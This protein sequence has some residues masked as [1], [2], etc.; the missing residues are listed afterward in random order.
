M[1]EPFKKLI[2]FSPAQVLAIEAYAIDND[3]VHGGNPHFS[4]AVRQL[5]NIG[6]QVELGLHALKLGRPVEPDE[7]IQSEL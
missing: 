5:I 2:K 7:P 4:A 1:D 6:M 3:L